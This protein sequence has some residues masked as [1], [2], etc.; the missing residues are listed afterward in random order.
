MQNS[1][2]RH[3]G[4][5]VVFV[6][7]ANDCFVFLLV[8]L[9][10]GIQ[11]RNNV[12]RGVREPVKH[13]NLADHAVVVGVSVYGSEFGSGLRKFREYIVQQVLGFDV[14]NLVNLGRVQSGAVAN[15]VGTYQGAQG[16]PLRGVLVRLAVVKHVADD[17]VPA[18]FDGVHQHGVEVVIGE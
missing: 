18:F 7:A 11:K 12:K 10:G 16:N 17:G 5:H 15:G 8:T 6:A 2:E 1:H 9:D 13:R 4:I 14:F 3:G